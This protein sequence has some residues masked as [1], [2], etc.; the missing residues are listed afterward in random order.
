MIASIE[1]IQE[2]VKNATGET[3]EYMVFP[4]HIKTNDFGLE[5]EFHFFNTLDQIG[6]ASMD[7]SGYVEECEDSEGFCMS[8]WNGSNTVDIYEDSY[9]DILNLCDLG[10]YKVEENG[11]FCSYE[12]FYLDVDS[13]DVYIQISCNNKEAVPEFR[14]V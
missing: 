1:K 2:L 7:E 3:E 13:G 12:Q 8:Y 4:A 14:K 5:A 10:E 9:E 6:R 11:C